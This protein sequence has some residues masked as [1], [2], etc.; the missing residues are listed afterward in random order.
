MVSEIRPRE[1]PRSRL[2]PSKGQICL[3]PGVLAGPCTIQARGPGL[4]ELPRALGTAFW[5]QIRP[6]LGRS[7]LLG[8]PHLFFWPCGP[9]HPG[10]AGRETFSPILS[11]R[12]SNIYFFAHF[13]TSCFKLSTPPKIFEA[14]SDKMGE[15]V[16]RPALPGL[17]GR[18]ATKNRCGK[19]RSRLRPSEGA[20]FVPRERPPGLWDAPRG[21]A[22]GPE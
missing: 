5:A 6:L 8:F 16:S 13:V 18:T 19:P 9:L 14:R 4:G 11:L 21:Q 22:H 17:R 7:R 1:K 15:K 2:R 12:A 3:G 20:G 10:R